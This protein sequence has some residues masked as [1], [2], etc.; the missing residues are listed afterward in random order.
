MRIANI[1]L[2]KE[3]Y[4]NLIFN[5]PCVAGAELQTPL[6]LINSLTDSTFSSKPLKYHYTQTVRARKLKFL[7]NVQPLTTCHMSGVMCHAPGVTFVRC[8]V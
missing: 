4:N 1:G 5:R 7:E 3:I 6:S 8:H 2:K